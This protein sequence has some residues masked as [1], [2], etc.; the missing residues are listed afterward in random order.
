MNQKKKKFNCSEVL[1]K[2]NL[3]F[4]GTKGH[5]SSNVKNQAIIF[6]LK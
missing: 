1:L 2:N 4:R 3:I 6:T 5:A